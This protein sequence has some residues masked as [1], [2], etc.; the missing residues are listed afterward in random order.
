MLSADGDVMLYKVDK[1]IIDDFDNLI[2]QFYKWK[3]TNC[4]DEQLFVKFLKEKCGNDSIIFV[5]NLG[6]IDEANIP[7][8]YKSIK[9]Y[10]F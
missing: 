6:W 8:E 3:R 7:V 5:K 1:I 2:K 10:N 4:Y 9:W